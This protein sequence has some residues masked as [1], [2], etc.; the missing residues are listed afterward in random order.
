V[1][2]KNKIE[3]IFFFFGMN[4]A[5]RNIAASGKFSIPVYEKNKF[6][7]SSLKENQSVYVIGNIIPKVWS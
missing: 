2:E 3:I 1:P 5:R 7:Q 4:R 6:L